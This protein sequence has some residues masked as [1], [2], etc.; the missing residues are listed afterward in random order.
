MIDRVVASA[1]R[2]S[3][4]MERIRFVDEILAGKGSGWTAQELRYVCSNVPAHAITTFFRGA[5]PC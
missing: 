3:F 1:G 5:A 4:S 2:I